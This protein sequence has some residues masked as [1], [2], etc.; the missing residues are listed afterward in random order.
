[1]DFRRLDGCPLEIGWTDRRCRAYLYLRFQRGRSIV[2]VGV[3]S[4]AAHRDVHHVSYTLTP[5]CL[6]AV[7]ALLFLV[8]E[9]NLRSTH[10]LYSTI[11][12]PYR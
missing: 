9:R 8:F 10:G 12:I 4:E 3:I 11:S 2:S 7:L 1:M 5:S 6:G